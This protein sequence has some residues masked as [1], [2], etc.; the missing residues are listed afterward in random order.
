MQSLSP[1]Q[2]ALV[3]DWWAGPSLL[4]LLPR[5]VSDHPCTLACNAPGKTSHALLVV[6]TAGDRCDWRWKFYEDS[7]LRSVYP[8]STVDTWYTLE[9]FEIQTLKGGTAQR[10]LDIYTFGAGETAG[11]P[12]FA[13]AVASLRATLA[14]VCS[15][16]GAEAKDGQ[17]ITGELELQD[18]RQRRLRRGSELYDGDGDDAVPLIPRNQA[19]DQ[20]ASMR[21]RVMTL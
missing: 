16:K 2:Q 20:C 1:P 3:S 11:V 5:E 7:W 10:V 9:D 18:L 12:V 17:E 19:F 13:P 21:I 15:K 6:C 8:S 14:F 4:E